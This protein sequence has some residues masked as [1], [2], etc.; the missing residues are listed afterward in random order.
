MPRNMHLQDKSIQMS[1]LTSVGARH[2]RMPPWIA[3]LPSWN[4][5]ELNTA[6]LH[7]P[8]PERKKKNDKTC[9]PKTCRESP[10]AYLR[11]PR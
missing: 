2:Q 10:P 6:P 9:Q 5:R 1:T 8:M 11:H 7:A 3:F 4:Y